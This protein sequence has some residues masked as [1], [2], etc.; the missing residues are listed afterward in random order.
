MR[1][2]LDEMVE[3]GSS[4]LKDSVINGYY[5]ESSNSGKFSV[6]SSTDYLF[7]HFYARN[8]LR[9]SSLKWKAERFS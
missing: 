3:G 5:S 6:I 1:Y 2:G 8:A 9:K 4:P 7:T